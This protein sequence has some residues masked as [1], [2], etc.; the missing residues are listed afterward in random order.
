MVDARARASRLSFDDVNLHVLYFNP[1]QQEIDFSHNH[2]FQM[3]SVTKQI[4]VTTYQFIKILSFAVQ[5]CLQK[6]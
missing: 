2:I 1:H 6:L 5:G 3:V 4:R